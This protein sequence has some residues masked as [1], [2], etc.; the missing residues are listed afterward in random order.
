MRAHHPDGVFLAY[1]PDL[2]A[3]IARRNIT[4]I[5]ATL[6]YSLGLE[7]PSDF[8]GRVPQAMFTAEQLERRPADRCVTVGATKNDAAVGMGQDEKAQIMAQLQLLGYME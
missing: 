4:D 7:V 6:L 3:T 1:G 2:K 5:C 8:E